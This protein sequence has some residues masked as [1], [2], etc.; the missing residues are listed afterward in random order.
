M[1][2]Q[3]LN[4]SFR[5][6]KLSAFPL[7]KSGGVLEISGDESV[8]KALSI[9]QKHDVLSAPV[10]SPAASSDSTWSVRYIGIIDHID[11]V[12]WLLDLIHS[13]G[14]PP[15]QPQHQ[16]TIMSNLE[17]TKVAELMAGKR[18]APFIPLDP[19][20][21]TLHDAM[22]LLGKYGLRR[23]PIVQ[24]STN[25]VTNIVTQSAVIRLLSQ[26]IPSD[27]QFAQFARQTLRDMRLAEPVPMF[28]VHE[29]DTVMHA[30]QLICQNHISAV[31]VLGKDDT[32]VGCV[33]SQ[34]VR[35]LITT[36]ES[37]GTLLLPLTKSSKLTKKY[38]SSTEDSRLS[39]VIKNLA[40]AHEHRTF[41]VNARKSP[42][43]VLSLRDVVACFATEPSVSYF[44]P[45]FASMTLMVLDQHMHLFDGL[46]DKTLSDAGI[47]VPEPVRQILATDRLLPACDALVRE[48]TDNLAAVIDP[49]SGSTISV[50]SNAMAHRTIALSL[51]QSSSLTAASVAV[52]SNLMCSVS[53]TVAEAISRMRAAHTRALVLLDDDGQPVRI[54]RDNELVKALTHHPIWA[55]MFYAGIWNDWLKPAPDQRTSPANVAFGRER[56]RSWSLH[57]RTRTSSVGAKTGSSPL[58][59]SPLGASPLGISPPKLSGLVLRDF[60]ADN[61]PP[62]GDLLD[63]SPDSSPRSAAPVDLP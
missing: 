13:H 24:A 11:I 28:S 54:L 12:W 51:G 44:R 4:A 32:L 55:E 35:Q 33:S 59:I 18:Y 57:G 43:R 49:D 19:D 37:L 62:R 20:V 15:N 53:C 29:S 22:L 16:K 30:L 2:L 8:M 21:H 36:P 58:G 63:S 26:I 52:D 34:F 42:V 9:L 39:D 14:L 41:V 25:R 45:Y 61:S 5:A 48:G 31:P 40:T 10:Y 38:L 17:T 1:S 3:G 60:T 50:L 7:P 27:Q 46:K 23:I 47:A 56:A 6:I